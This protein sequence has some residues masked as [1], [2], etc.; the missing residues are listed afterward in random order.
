MTDLVIINPAAIED[1][2]AIDLLFLLID[3]SKIEEDGDFQYT[4]EIDDDKE[5]EYFI[6]ALNVIFNHHRINA[7]IS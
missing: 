1:A 5:K 6:E 2:K 3:H 7:D 4:I